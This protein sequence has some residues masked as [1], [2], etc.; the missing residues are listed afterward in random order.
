ML[1]VRGGM[2]LFSGDTG[3]MATLLGAFFLGAFFLGAFF[4]GA[5]FLDPRIRTG[6]ATGESQSN[7]GDSADNGER[8]VNGDCDSPD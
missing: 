2:F 7:T 1:N 4:L 3:S 6:R 8:S 5:F